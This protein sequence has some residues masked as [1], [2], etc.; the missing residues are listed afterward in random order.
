MS[1]T[2]KSYWIVLLLLA[3]CQSFDRSANLTLINRSGKPV[4]YWVS[5]DSSYRDLELK[6]DNLLKAHD[7]IKPY[8][9]YGPEGKGP[10]KNSWVNAIN[11]ADDT[12]LHVFFF[13]ID[14]KDDK[15]LTDSL[16]HL[17]IRRFDYRVNALNQLHWRI[18][19]NAEM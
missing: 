1:P 16:Y 11:R 12:A 15:N 5:C 3:G 19:Y 13:Y 17:I 14:F 10:D 6:S 2:R 18:E 9:L 4:Y 7:S 8:L